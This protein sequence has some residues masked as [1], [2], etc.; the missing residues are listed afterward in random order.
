[1]HNLDKE[2]PKEKEPLSDEPKQ[3]ARAKPTEETK[4][5]TLFEG[6]TSKQ[7]IIFDKLDSKIE[8]KLIQFLRDNSD[9]F[10]RST[11]ELRGVDRSIIEH[12]LDVNKNHPW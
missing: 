12:I 6:N 3:Q 9:I 11:E 2:K 7:V 10:A 5:V 1:M 8:S 4:K